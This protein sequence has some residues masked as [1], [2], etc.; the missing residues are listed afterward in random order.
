MRDPL[1]VLVALMIGFVGVPVAAFLLFIVVTRVPA[2]RF[3]PILDGLDVPAG[4]EAVHTETVDGGFLIRARAT[5]YYFADVA[6]REDAVEA[7]KAVVTAAGFEFQPQQIGSDKCLD[8]DPT[9]PCTHRPLEDCPPRSDTCVVEAIRSL[10]SDDERVDHLWIVI[11]DPGVSF[12]VRRGDD[13]RL[14]SDPD[15]VR[16]T[17]TAHQSRREAFEA[18]PVDWTPPTSQ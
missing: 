10:T 17:I 3:V 7:A 12:E 11:D 15:R 5:R 6:R 1:R 14:V 13:R 8:P 4:W 18:H 9:T 16:V 2:E